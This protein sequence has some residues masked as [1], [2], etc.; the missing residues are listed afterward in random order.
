VEHR[1]NLILNVSVFVVSF[2][3]RGIL[4]G[5]HTDRYCDC[6][7]IMAWGNIERK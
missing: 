3:E 1:K 6:C 2:W 7:E 5:I 4:R